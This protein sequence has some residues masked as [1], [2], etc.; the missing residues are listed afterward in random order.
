MCN[1][2]AF[3]QVLLN[4]IKTSSFYLFKLNQDSTRWKYEY[5]TLS[6]LDSYVCT[7]IDHPSSHKHQ[8]PIYIPRRLV[9]IH[10]C[11]VET[12]ASYSL[13]P[14]CASGNQ[15]R[16]PIITNHNEVFLHLPNNGYFAG[17]MKKTRSVCET[18][19]PGGNKVRKTYEFYNNFST[20]GIVKVTRS[21]V[22][23]PGLTSGLQGSVN[24]HRGALLLVPQWQCISSFVFYI[25]VI[26]KG[27]ITATYIFSYGFKYKKILL[28][29]CLH[30]FKSD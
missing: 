15:S 30:H 1:N 9:R 8:C 14:W 11:R 17:D 24:V 3:A 25:G 19:C 21:S 6:H 7:G 26:Q 28:L 18:L 20:K 2:T 5:S 4:K 23:T 16:A 10:H 12:R 22:I 29:K 13:R 27:I